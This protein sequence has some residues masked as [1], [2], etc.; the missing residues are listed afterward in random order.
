MG[1]EPRNSEELD[2]LLAEARREGPG[3]SAAARGRILAESTRELPG[4][5]FW[6]PLF[7]PTSR[8]LAAGALPLALAVGLMALVDRGGVQA[9]P[10]ILGHK[11]PTVEVAKVGDRVEFKVSNGGRP[12]WVSRSTSPDEFDPDLR[13]R[14]REGAF[15][16]NL[17]DGTTLVF[18]RIE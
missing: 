17:E 15:A 13:V 7:A 9:P 18:Y 16:D 4:K 10:T 12:H 11:S 8:V 14:M 5:A 6:P 2:R 3:L 1:A